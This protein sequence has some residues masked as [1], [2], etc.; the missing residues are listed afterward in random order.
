MT[1]RYPRVMQRWL[2]G[3]ALVIAACKG[4]EA[5]SA[6][7]V[8]TTAAATTATAPVTAT[9][10][11]PAASASEGLEAAPQRGYLERRADG[12]CWWNASEYCCPP[13]AM[14]K[15]TPPERRVECPPL[16]PV[17]DG[18]P[19]DSDDAWMER[20]ADGKCWAGPNARALHRT[21]CCDER[22]PK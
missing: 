11:T 1:R 16:A 6:P 13:K 9:A 15:P 10:T 7:G 12:S 14:C 18:P 20:R 21:L 19:R 8:A 2:I 5:P 22:Y 3:G 17:V 4:T